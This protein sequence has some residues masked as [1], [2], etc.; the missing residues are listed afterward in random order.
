MASLHAENST[1]FLLQNIGFF[2][3]KTAVTDTISKKILLAGGDE[4]YVESWGFRRITNKEGDSSFINGE[5]IP[6]MNRSLEL[7]GIQNNKIKP[8]LFT[9]R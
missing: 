3:I 8:N 4:V 7:T 2:N 1:S 6:A 5:H 9:R